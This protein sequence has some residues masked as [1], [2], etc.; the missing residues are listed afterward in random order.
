[1]KWRQHQW[2]VKR[3]N[4]GVISSEGNGVGGVNE[5]KLMAAISGGGESIEAA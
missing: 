1:M 4:G 3:R 2:Q 5:E